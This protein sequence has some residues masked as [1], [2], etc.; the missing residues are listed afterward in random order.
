MID[1]LTQLE[2]LKERAADLKQRHEDHQ[3]E[4]QEMVAECAAL[5]Q[6]MKKEMGDLGALFP[7]LLEVTHTLDMIGGLKL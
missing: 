7:E 6:R 3:A 1:V 2:A 5:S 4:F